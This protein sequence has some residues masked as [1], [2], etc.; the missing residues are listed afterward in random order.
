MK[1][2]IDTNVL[3]S[4]L[5]FSGTP[6]RILKA[7]HTGQF[8]LLLSDEILHEYKLVLHE[9]TQKKPVLNPQKIVS[10]IRHTAHFVK[11]VTL[12]HQVCTDKDDDKFI[13]CALAAKAII[14]T[15]D[16]ALLKTAGYKNL[17]VLTPSEFEQRYLI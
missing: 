16:K 12:H 4:G 5:F 2:V 15:G 14:V 10:F 1:V 8:Q 17:T 13:A 11:P 3:V 7:W 9:M 6:A